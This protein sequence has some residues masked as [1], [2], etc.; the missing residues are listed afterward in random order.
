VTATGRPSML[1]SAVAGMGFWNNAIIA[2]SKRC[3]G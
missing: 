2:A 1:V 3:G